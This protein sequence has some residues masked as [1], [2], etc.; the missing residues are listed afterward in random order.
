MWTALLKRVEEWLFERHVVA[1]VTKPLRY[2]YAL[3]R[4]LLRGDLTLR[5][6]SLVYTTLLSIVPLLAL[7][8]SVL[9]GL[10]YH[11]VLEPV[12]F[13]FLE[14]IG[15]KAA[16]FTEETMKFIEN[17]R[18]GVLG[19]VGLVFLV[20]TSISMI[21][22]IE[23]SFNFVWRVK[24]PRGFGRR[25]S[26]YI[27]VLL[28][29]P[30]L[31]VAALGMLTTLRQQ[32]VVKAITHIAP[33]GTLL[34]WLSQSTPYVLVIGVFAFLYGFVPNTR[35]RMRSAL[36]GGVVAGVV[37]SA[38]GHLFTSFFGGATG[39]LIVYA[40]FAVV[41]LALV[42]LYLSWL[43]LL[44]GAQLAF[45][46]QHPY[47]LR[48]NAG[49]VQLTPSLAERLGLSTMYLLAREFAKGAGETRA[50]FTLNALA[51]RMF[52]ASSVL[53]PIVNR[54]LQDGLLAIAEDESLMPGRDLATITLADILHSVRNAPD[55]ALSYIRNVDQAENI[56][57]QADL[58]LRT[59]VGAKTLKEWVSEKPDA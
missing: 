54:L 6:M 14:P 34:L 30:G 29:G 37:W 57:R 48:P 24:E 41:I 9:K 20:Y 53:E 26:E 25:V 40:G 36:I 49:I 32:T 59:S 39:T 8:F 28:I 10:G 1:G 47:C 22:K 12:I 50:H 55:P 52:L 3:A 4:D 31:I 46:V 56:A 27:S 18:G 33:F 21:Q 19:S 2:L 16:T 23:E 11:R 7:S 15:E 13:H 17:I 42:W 58:G 38:S 43:I 44:L 45:Y 5:A 51:E 35:V